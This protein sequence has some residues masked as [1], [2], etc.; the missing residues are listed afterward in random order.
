[1]KIRTDFVTNSSSSSFV[2]DL[3]LGFRDAKTISISHRYFTGDAET[4]SLEFGNHHIVYDDWSADTEVEDAEAEH[5]NT[6]RINLSEILHSK[7]SLAGVLNDLFYSEESEDDY[8]DEEDE[9]DT[10]GEDDEAGRHSAL[11][12]LQKDLATTLESYKASRR[13]LNEASVRMMFSGRGEGLYG[14]EESLYKI[15]DDSTVEKIKEAVKR[16]D[17]TQE[18]ISRLRTIE[19]LKWF[20]DESLENLALFY[21]ECDWTPQVIVIIQKLTEGKKIHMDIIWTDDESD[22]RLEGISLY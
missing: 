3:D 15:F 21:K 13:N 5:I 8:Y 6:N 14:F 12:D 9:Y 20:D 7:E 22:P 1:M 19:K 16:A 10:A 4:S 11:E 18:A 2:V 17:G